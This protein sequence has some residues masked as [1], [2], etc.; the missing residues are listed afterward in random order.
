M[1]LRPLP[2]RVNVP[3][4]VGWAA[5][6]HPA[7]RPSQRLCRQTRA[8][9]SASKAESGATGLLNS[10]RGGGLAAR[11]LTSSQVTRAPRVG[12][13]QG[14]QVRP[15]CSPLGA[16][17]AAHSF[18]NGP[19]GLAEGFGRVTL[20]KTPPL[21]AS[22]CTPRG[23]AGAPPTAA[24]EWKR[25][26]PHARAVTTRPG[27]AWQ[28][29]RALASCSGSLSRQAPPLMPCSRRGSE[30]SFRPARAQRRNFSRGAPRPPDS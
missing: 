20:W 12:A 9:R 11:A 3:R 26:K 24:S 28:G 15:H 10:T 8:R 7:L 18:E 13:D 19:E 14:R 2:L 22:G 25:R 27:T 21:C 6:E 30:V 16:A 29:A 5:P 4:T 23:P 1:R 17:W